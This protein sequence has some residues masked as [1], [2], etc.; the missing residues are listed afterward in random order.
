MTPTPEQIRKL[1]KAAG[2]SGSRAGALVGV[3]GRTVR[4]WT[5]GQTP[6]PSAAWELL[7]IKTN[8]HPFYLESNMNAKQL[9]DM[10]KNANHKHSHMSER[11]CSWAS[12]DNRIAGSYKRESHGM[13]NGCIT[14]DYI[15]DDGNE[16]NLEIEPSGYVRNWIDCVKET[17]DHLK[18]FEV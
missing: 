5:G 4:R 8:N 2:L 16:H 13:E 17:R 9:L 1:L 6:M 7:L 3:D 15:D 10:M 12:P 14:V 11:P 18:E